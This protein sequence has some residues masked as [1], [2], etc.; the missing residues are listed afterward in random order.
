MNMQHNTESSL[1]AK[2]GSCFINLASAGEKNRTENKG[3]EN[4]NPYPTTVIRR[5]PT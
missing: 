2:T 5:Y 3:G 1:S 4:K